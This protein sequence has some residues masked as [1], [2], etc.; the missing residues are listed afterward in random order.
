MLRKTCRLGTW[1]VRTLYKIG[2][3]KEVA[4][5][6]NV[7]KLDTPGIT[8]TRWTG[9]GRPTLGTMVYSGHEEEDAN[10]TKG[11]GLMLS[12]Q[13]AKSPHVL[14]WQP[15][16]SSIVS[17]MLKTNKKNINLRDINCYAS[18]NEKG[19][20]HRRIHKATWISPNFNLGTENQRDN[21]CINHSFR[22]SLQNVKVFRVAD[23]GLDHHLVAAKIRSKLRRCKFAPHQRP[24]YNVNLLS[25]QQKREE[26]AI[27]VSN[28]FYALGTL[29]EVENIK[30]YWNQI[31]GVWK[32]S[33]EEAEVD[34]GIDLEPPSKEE[35]LAAIKKLRNKAAGLDGITGDAHKGKFGVPSKG[36]DWIISENIDNRGVS[37]RMERRT[38][39]QTPKEREYLECGNNGGITVLSV[40]GKVFNGVLLERL[41]VALVEKLREEQA[42]FR[43]GKSCEDQIAALRIIRE[44]TLEWNSPLCIGELC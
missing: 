20:D 9:N 29:G 11:E 32:E 35:I 13:A 2:K 37:S 16:G 27:E 10:H 18:T 15:E 1:N 24:K 26:Y 43:K 14:R 4:R 33:C 44:H 28:K 7:Y 41:K 31:K 34:L 22:S 19:E 12:R 38:Y 5:E 25:S 39:C 3:L 40:P 36:S 30:D 17:A 42:R 6:F 8:E 21:I 23:I